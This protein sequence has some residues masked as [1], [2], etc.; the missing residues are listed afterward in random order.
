MIGKGK[1]KIVFSH[2]I[3]PYGRIG[4]FH[5]LRYEGLEVMYYV[6][7]LRCLAYE[8]LQSVQCVLSKVIILNS[9][10]Y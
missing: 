2:H 8:S 1:R 5:M 6:F 4:G 7:T 10:N 3:S 9:W